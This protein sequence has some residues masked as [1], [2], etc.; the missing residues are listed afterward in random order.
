MP[1]ND[2][3]MFR[4]LCHGINSEAAHFP[5]SRGRKVKTNA[6]TNAF[7]S[8]VAATVGIS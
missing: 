8:S 4:R 5:A 6:K 7:A 2:Y 3:L 1:F